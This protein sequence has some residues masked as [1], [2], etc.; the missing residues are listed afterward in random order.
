MLNAARAS[1]SAFRRAVTP[2]ERR[3]ALHVR[4]PGVDLDTPI[5]RHWF[6]DNLVATHIANGVNMLFP[7]GE[8]FF[9]RSVN[10][11]ADRVKSPALREQI[12]G[13]FGQEGRHA[14][15]HDR[16]TALLEEQGFD[17]DR[18]MRFY[19]ALAYKMIERASPPELRLATTAACEHFTALLAENALRYGVLQRA[20]PA[21]R[22]LLMWHAAEEIEHRAV[23][24][25]V[26]QEVNPSYALRVAGLGMATL[27]LGGFWWLGAASLMVQ[28]D[29]LNWPRLRQDWKTFRANRPPEAVFVRGIRQYLRPDFHPT[30]SDTDAL[31]AQYLSAVGLA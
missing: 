17:I 29:A 9:V 16:V 21:M 7:R 2:P 30:Q 31:A 6:G 24:F 4:S 15:E 5:P 8:R 19:E 18:F 11:Y 25:D 27:M 14:K 26:L 12:R 23:A 22:E 1:T 10:Y 28:D 13:F 3:P 20:H